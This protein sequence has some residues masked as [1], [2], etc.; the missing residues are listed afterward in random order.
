MLIGGRDAGALGLGTAQFAFRDDLT[1][2]QSIA[3]ITAAVDQGVTLIDTALAYS[4][5]NESG[6]AENLVR[7]ALQGHGH[8]DDVLVAT[9]GG[10]YRSG[11]TFPIDGRPEALRA[12]CESSLIA[13]GAERIDLYQLHWIGQSVPLSDSVGA[14]AELQSEGKIDHIGLSNI[15]E[16]QLQEARA[17]VPIATVQN[18][19]SVD[20][21][22]DLPLARLCASLGIGYLAYMP[23]GGYNKVPRRDDACVSVAHRHGVSW[24]QVALAW[25][26]L[27]PNVIPLVGSSR[28]ETMRDSLQSRTLCLLPE[29]VALLPHH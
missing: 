16:S 29:D 15:D 23:L 22:D 14:L 19:L 8:K 10:H 11:D 4:R 1:P 25:L 28:P 17:I 26:L 21:P 9:K 5:R 2:E 12:H 7:R 24:Q 3:S 6:Y 18:R 20:H 27:Q 13:L